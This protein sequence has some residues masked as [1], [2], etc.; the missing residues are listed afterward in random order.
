MG[1]F[2]PR[3]IEFVEKETPI[4]GQGIVLTRRPLRTLLPLIAQQPVVLQSGQQRVERSFHYQQF[5]FLQLLD[6]V[7]CIGR[8]L[9]KQ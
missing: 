6:D 1:Y 3:L 7:G 9:L 5:R 8:P 2:R 4:I